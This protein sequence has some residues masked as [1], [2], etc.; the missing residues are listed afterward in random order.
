MHSDTHP[1]SHTT[2]F[3]GKKE[4]QRGST[5]HRD[6]SFKQMQLI[7]GVVKQHGGWAHQKFTTMRVFNRF[8]VGSESNKILLFWV[9][10][11]KAIILLSSHHTK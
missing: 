11:N 3:K 9:T 1:S 5:P 8:Q 6:T 4:P 10:T 7:R 2:K